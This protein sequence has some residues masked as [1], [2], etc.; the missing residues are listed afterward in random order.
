MNETIDR[1]L[2]IGNVAEVLEWG[3]HVVPPRPSR[4]HSAKR[5]F[6]RPS[7]QSDF[8]CPRRPECVRPQSKAKPTRRGHR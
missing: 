5:Q 3:A 7:K 4:Q 6:I 1:L 2:A 8:Q